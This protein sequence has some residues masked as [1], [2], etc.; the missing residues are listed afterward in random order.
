MPKLVLVFDKY[1]FPDEI[2]DSIHHL[3]CEAYS[4]ECHIRWT[5]GKKIDE[6]GGQGQGYLK[7]E[8]VAAI[9]AF[10]L[11]T[12]ADEGQAVLIHNHW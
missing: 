1:E 9:D 2:Q 5:A 12:G 7:D 4:G 8:Q 3:A 11:K 10:L 6:F